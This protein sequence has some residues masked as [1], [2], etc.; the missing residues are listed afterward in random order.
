MPYLY[1]A[2]M[3]KEDILDIIAYIRSLSPLENKI[4]ESEAD[5]PMNFI[6]NTMPGKPMFTQKPDRQNKVEYG[7]YL[8]NVASCVD[9]HTPV[10]NG[11][12]IAEKAFSGG[13]EFE[14]PGG[15]LRSANI[16]P[17]VATGIGSWTDSVFVSRFKAYQNL[18]S[19]PQVEQEGY[20]TLM[21]WTMYAGMERA[22]LEAIHAY[23]KTL[24][25]I[26]NEIIRWYRKS[27]NQN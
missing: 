11:Q 12:I 24:A 2:K 13:R 6:I 4:P 26:E 8:V 14:L 10:N 3:N 1:Y 19:L 27:K 18:D 22:D 20:N 25:P 23:L 7:K 15:I 21:P 5:F 17:D 9:C 16:T